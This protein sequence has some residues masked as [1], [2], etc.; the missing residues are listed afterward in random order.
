MVDDRQGDWKD[1]CRGPHLPSTGK[2]GKA[3]RLTKLA[4]AYWRG[5]SN[6]E[7]LQRIYGTCWANEKQLKAYLTMIEEAEKRDHQTDDPKLQS[8]RISF[9]T[10]PRQTL[11]LANMYMFKDDCLENH[12]ERKRLEGDRHVPKREGAEERRRKLLT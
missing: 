11:D 5:D 2:L 8:V 10:A 3:F 6:N 12:I 1:L 7:M 9:H 4:G